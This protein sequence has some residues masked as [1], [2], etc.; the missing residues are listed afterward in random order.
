MRV[1]PM[2]EMKY[3]SPSAIRIL[4]YAA[5]RCISALLLILDVFC[6]MFSLSII[7]I[8]FEATVF[9]YFN[10]SYA[11]YQEN[12]N[13][14]YMYVYVNFDLHWNKSTLRRIK[15]TKTANVQNRFEW[16]SNKNRIASFYW[17]IVRCFI[18]DIFIWKW[19]RLLDL[20]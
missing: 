8:A 12:S 15:F 13:S 20:D 7:L 1:L 10:K 16:M 19:R 5:I 6:F 14:K 2:V 11:I 4:F 9:H 3:V 18:F 17:I